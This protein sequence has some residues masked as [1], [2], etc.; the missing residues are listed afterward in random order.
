MIAL[1]DTRRHHRNTNALR[2]DDGGG[3]ARARAWAWAWAESEQRGGRSLPF[4]L[5]PV[6]ECWRAS[7]RATHFEPPQGAIVY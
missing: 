3:Q 2:R 4:R 5:W 6:V 7:H 1:N